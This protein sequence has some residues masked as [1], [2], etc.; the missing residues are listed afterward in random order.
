MKSGKKAPGVGEV[1]RTF[2]ESVLKG[3]QWICRMQ[4]FVLGISYAVLAF[5]LMNSAGWLQVAG[6]PVILDYAL[7]AML[8]FSTLIVFTNVFMGWEKASFRGTAIFILFANGTMLTLGSRA[9]ILGVE[10]KALQSIMLGASTILIVASVVLLLPTV[11]RLSKL[12]VIATKTREFLELQKDI[13]SRISRRSAEAVRQI[14]DDLIKLYYQSQG[15]LSTV[16]MDVFKPMGLEESNKRLLLALLISIVAAILHFSIEYWG[17]SYTHAALYEMAILFVGL[18]AVW[19]WSTWRG[20][21]ARRYAEILEI[22]KKISE[23]L[24]QS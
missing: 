2:G 10:P 14:R 11:A 13:Y 16:F 3:I 20:K 8:A 18:I 5:V 17:M 12:D 9:E 24:E 1:A 7:I 21:E 22:G 23:I 19:A 4:D 6:P 15:L